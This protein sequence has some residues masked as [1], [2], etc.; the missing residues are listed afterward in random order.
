[1]Q[2]NVANNQLSCLGKSATL[3]PIGNKIKLQILVDRTSIEVFGND[4]RVS[5]SSCFLPNLDNTNLGV[6]ADGGDV[7]IT[8]LNVF[9]LRSV[10]DDIIF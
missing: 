4:G 6:Y 5:L 10:W 8:S 3:R 1:M 9:E 7:K 2:Y